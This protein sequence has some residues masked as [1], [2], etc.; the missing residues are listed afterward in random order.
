MTNLQQAPVIGSHKPFYEFTKSRYRIA[1]F[2]VLMFGCFYAWPRNVLG[3]GSVDA[4]A[5][6]LMM[7]VSVALV[8]L[9]TAWS[10]LYRFEHVRDAFN[11]ANFIDTLKRIVWF[12]ATLGWASLMNFSVM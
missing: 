6:S 12:V 9:F 3:L 8:A 4:S 7:Q 5:M 10:C 2:A 1:L 11:E